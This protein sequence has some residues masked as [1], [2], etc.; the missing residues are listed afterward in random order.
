[1]AALKELLS[2][3]KSSSSTFYDHSSD[4]WFKQRYSAPTEDEHIET[5]TTNHVPIYNTPEHLKYRPSKP[6][7]FGDSGAFPEPG[8]TTGSTSSTL[9][10]NMPFGSDHGI[11]SSSGDDRQALFW[12]KDYEHHPEKMEEFISRGFVVD[13]D[14]FDGNG[15]RYS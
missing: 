5:I 8:C 3:A 2:P 6:Q 7:D 14:E 11:G 13:G 9:L 12:S 1:M 15:S 10:E 4:P